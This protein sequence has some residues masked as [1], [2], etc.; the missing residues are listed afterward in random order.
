MDSIAP[1]VRPRRMKLPRRRECVSAEGHGGRSSVIRASLHRH[2]IP[3]DAHD[4]GHDANCSVSFGEYQPLFDVQ[5]DVGRH[6]V[7]SGESADQ[8]APLRR[9][10][11]RSRMRG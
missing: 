6:G 1:A 7:M 5:L 8:A 4:R 11:Y 2:L 9:P 10:R 3:P